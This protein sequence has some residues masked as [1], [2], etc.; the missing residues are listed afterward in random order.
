MEE[1]CRRK[2]KGGG[3]KKAKL[4]SVRVEKSLG[5]RGDQSSCQVFSIG[6]FQ[7]KISG[8]EVGRRQESL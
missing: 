8:N 3:E 2:S 6:N 4:V 7:G 1:A 5:H